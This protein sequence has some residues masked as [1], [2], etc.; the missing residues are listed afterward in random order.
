MDDGGNIFAENSSLSGTNN[1]H[2]L[3]ASF[4]S[5][6]RQEHIL[7]NDKLLTDGE[8]MVRPDSSDTDY[9]S[10]TTSNSQGPSGCNLNTR[11]N[12]TLNQNVHDSLLNSSSSFPPPPKLTCMAPLSSGGSTN[13]IKGVNT[14]IGAINKIET[15]DD[16]LHDPDELQLPSSPS[17]TSWISKL[18]HM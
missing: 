15:C 3:H 14:F 4:D 9:C 17:S 10:P 11:Q 7:R 8:A 13:G 18:F 12:F 16:N 6:I 1:Q 2:G 5:D